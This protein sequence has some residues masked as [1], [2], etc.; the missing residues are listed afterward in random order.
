MVKE[1]KDNFYE[2]RLP[3]LNS[4]STE[5]R[6][7]RGNQIMCYKILNNKVTVDEHVLIKATETRTRGHS[8]KL[9]KW[10]WLLAKWLWLFH[11]FGNKEE[12]L[13]QQSG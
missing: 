6:K 1:L 3:K 7:E 9:A 10:L 2:E 4:M 8:M 11:G 12:L 13:L 5:T